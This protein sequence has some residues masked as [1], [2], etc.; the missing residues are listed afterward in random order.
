MACICGH[1]LIIYLYSLTER[2]LKTRELTTR[3]LTTTTKKPGVMQTK[4]S[5][6]PGRGVKCSNDVIHCVT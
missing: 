1:P 6:G 5:K 4:G 3:E 2:E